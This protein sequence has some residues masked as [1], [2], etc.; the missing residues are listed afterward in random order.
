MFQRGMGRRQKKLSRLGHQA[1]GMRWQFPNRLQSI[2][3]VLCSFPINKR[4]I[5][6]GLKAM[7]EQM[8]QFVEEKEDKINRLTERMRTQN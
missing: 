4:Q 3:L 5:Y 8:E 7:K 2:Y 6:F 1:C